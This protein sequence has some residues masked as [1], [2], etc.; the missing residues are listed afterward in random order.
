MSGKSVRT[1]LFSCLMTKVACSSGGDCEVFRPGRKMVLIAPES[2]ARVH[3][4]IKPT[5]LIHG[6]FEDRGVVAN[7]YRRILDRQFNLWLTQHPKFSRWIND[8]GSS[9]LVVAGEFS[10]PV[11]VAFGKQAGPVGGNPALPCYGLRAVLRKSMWA[12]L[13]SGFYLSTSYVAPGRQEGVN[14]VV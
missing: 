9:A 2:A 3:F 12:G 8:R 4:I 5:K 7:L 10:R 11:G 6:F 1:N 14:P 13:M